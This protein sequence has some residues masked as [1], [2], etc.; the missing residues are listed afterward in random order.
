MARNLS[1]DYAASARWAR[2]AGIVRA[3]SW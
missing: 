2:S 1:G 3:R